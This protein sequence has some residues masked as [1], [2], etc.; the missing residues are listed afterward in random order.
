MRIINYISLHVPIHHRGKN[1]E[2]QRPRYASVY[3]ARPLGQRGMLYRRTL[4]YQA[5]MSDTE[6][7]L[8]VRKLI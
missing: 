5:I 4:Q 1:N 8:S 6:L 7:L 2:L 3:R